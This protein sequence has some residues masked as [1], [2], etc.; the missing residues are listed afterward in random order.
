MAGDLTSVEDAARLHALGYTT[1]AIHARWVLDAFRVLHGRLTDGGEPLVDTGDFDA[2]RLLGR[3]EWREVAE[4]ARVI[5]DLA[6]VI[7]IYLMFEAD[8]DEPRRGEDDE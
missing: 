5:A 1:R 2:S 3:D 8:A 4:A 6:P 7:R